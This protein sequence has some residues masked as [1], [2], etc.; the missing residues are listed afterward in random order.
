MGRQR[1]L[2]RDRNC[3]HGRLGA[4][5][6]EP[7]A[8]QAVL[9]AGSQRLLAGA[10]ALGRR[11]DGLSRLVE[12]P[13][14]PRLGPAAR[15]RFCGEL[16]VPGSGWRRRSA[17]CIRWTRVVA[18]DFELKNALSGV[19]YMGGALASLGLNRSGSRGFYVAALG[20]P[21]GSSAAPARSRT[22]LPSGR[23]SGVF[24]GSASD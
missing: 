7:G 21:N 12:H 20:F 8:T 23:C 19:C 15:R 6:T 13:P 16:E 9:S 4:D 5:L 11:V 2:T 18:S 3:A 10:E 17:A 1:P 14:A 22:F 24:G